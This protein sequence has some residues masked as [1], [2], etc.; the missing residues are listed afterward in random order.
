MVEDKEKGPVFY[1]SDNGAGFPESFADKL[2]KPFQR[3]HSLEEFEGTG[4]GLSIVKTI[5]NKHNGEIWASSKENEGA[6][7]Y[8]TL[9]K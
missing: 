1:I 6:T 4:V 9:P 8:F 2:F 3:G 5:I 7:F